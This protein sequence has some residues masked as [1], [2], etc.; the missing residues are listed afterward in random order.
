MLG[1]VR[2]HSRCWC[3]RDDIDCAG[4]VPPR[5]IAVPPRRLFRRDIVIKDNN[6]VDI[7][8]RP[9]RATDL[10]AEQHDAPRGVDLD[11]GVQ[12]GFGHGDRGG[13]LPNEAKG[14]IPVD[15]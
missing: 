2:S 5:R 9:S 8:L 4:K 6:K 10:T 15:R 13:S 3:C 11:N 7:A 1:A 14:F 12:Q